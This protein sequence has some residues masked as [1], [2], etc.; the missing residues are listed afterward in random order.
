MNEI[1][2]TTCE[3]AAFVRRAPRTLRQWAIQGYP[4]QPIRITG[5]RTPLLWRK[6]DLEKLLGIESEVKSAE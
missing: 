4:V 2:L 1:H 5:K 3:A 6:S